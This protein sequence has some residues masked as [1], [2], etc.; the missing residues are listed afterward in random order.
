MEISISLSYRIEEKNA[1]DRRQQVDYLTRTNEI[2]SKS[3][4]TAASRPVPLPSPSLPVTIASLRTA[5]L[6]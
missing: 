2:Y 4:G 5:P 6:H 1:A 3:V